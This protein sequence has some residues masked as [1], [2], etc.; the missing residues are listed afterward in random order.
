VDA[1]VV[2]LTCN[3]NPVIA[4]P[5]TT[6]T[7]TLNGTA[8]EATSVFI[9]SDQ[10]FFLPDSSGSVTVPAGAVSPALSLTTTLVPDQLVAHL[11]ASALA[12]ATVTAPLTI[13]LTN[14]RRRSLLNNV[15]F[16]DGGTAT[17]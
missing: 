4:G 16:K 14:R 17:G 6:C 9:L 13:T 3:P 12:T 1:T 8:P 15:A 7:G 2:G 5:T 11:S 10:P